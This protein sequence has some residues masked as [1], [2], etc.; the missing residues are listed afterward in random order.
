MK[1][2]VII[3]G[4]A[5]FLGSH[6][7]KH[8]VDKYNVVGIDDLSGGFEQNIP[9][10]V[11]FHQG[12]ILNEDLLETL[13]KYHRPKFVFHLAAYAAEGLSHFIRKY[14][15]ENNVIGSMNIINKCVQY[16]VKC[17]VFT[18][19]IAVYGEGMPPFHENEALRPMDP[20]GVA[21]AAVEMDLNAAL[22][23]FG[24]NHIIFRPHNIFGPHQN[25]GDKYR[26][27][28]GIF[29]NQIMKGE[30]LT[31][32]GDG[33]QTRAFSYVDDVAPHIANCVDREVCYNQVYNIGGDTSYTV[34]ELALA[35]CREFKVE[36]NINFLQAR[37]EAK[38]A[39]CDHEKAIGYFGPPKTD[40][41]AGIKQMAEWAKANGARESKPFEKIELTK[42]LPEGWK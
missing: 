17:L 13:F 32:F 1:E 30:P 11:N 8:L 9:F 12:S 7:A 10:G 41:Y 18:S 31:I 36:P 20:Y 25:I 6:V 5:G 33:S 40:L 22:Q 23:M 26:N 21:K 2:S 35:V 29:M 38:H 4:V 24:L 39:S 3:T 42:N 27:V 19:S 34:L 16:E 37:H 28:V 14:N 15:Y